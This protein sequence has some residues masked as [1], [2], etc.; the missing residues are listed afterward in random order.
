MKKETEMYNKILEDIKLSGLSSAE[1]VCI[2]IDLSIRYKP[3]FE[4][5]LNVGQSDKNKT[6]QTFVTTQIH[7]LVN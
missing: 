2:D 1:E 5:H 6:K 3:L 7:L 4:K